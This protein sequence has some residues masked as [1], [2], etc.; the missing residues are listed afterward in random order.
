VGAVSYARE[1][2]AFTVALTCVPGSP[3]TNSAEVSI[4]PVVGPEVIA[5][6]TR[7]KAGSAQKMVLNMLS[8]ASLVKLGY[9]TGNRMTNLQPRNAKLRER[10]VRIIMA[11]TGVSESVARDALKAANGVQKAIEQLRSLNATST[12]R[13]QATLPNPE[14]S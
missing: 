5:G 10:A 8:T 3:I 4:V 14:T 7:L 13:G 2:G 9:V 6:S 1:L 12:E 11:E